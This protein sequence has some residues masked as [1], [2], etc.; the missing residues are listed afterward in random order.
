MHTLSECSDFKTVVLICSEKVWI[1][2]RTTNN[3]FIVLYSMFN[4]LIFL[5]DVQKHEKD[6][7]VY[8][9]YI[10]SK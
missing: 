7:Y 3:I 8:C 9:S 5:A 6:V 1:E 10:I 4:A 2:F